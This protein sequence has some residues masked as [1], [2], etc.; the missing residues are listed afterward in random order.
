MIAINPKFI[1]ITLFFAA[2]TA[3]VQLN[4]PEYIW[5]P[6]S[7]WGLYTFWAVI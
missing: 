2:L 3:V 4:Y 7:V 5:Y 1:A 6:V